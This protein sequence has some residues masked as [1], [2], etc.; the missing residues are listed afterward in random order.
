VSAAV[1]SGRDC[2]PG[3]PQR[4]RVGTASWT[5]PTLIS[6]GTFYPPDAK[7]AEERLRFYAEHFDTVEVD[8]TYYALPSEKNAE[9]W[10]ERTPEGFVFHVKA[11]A[12]L[13]THAAETARLPRAIREMLSEEESGKPRLSRP[14]DEVLAL[15]FQMFASALEP[16]RRAGKLGFLLFQFPPWFSA[17]RGNA[18]TI[19]ACRERLPADALAVEF[20]HSSWLDESRRARTF[21]L[22]RDLDCAYVVVDEPQVAGA[23]PPLFETT[24]A[25]AYVRLHGRN[26]ETWAKKGISPA[27]RFK[28]LYSERELAEVAAR[29]KKLGARTAHV[30]FN[31]C[32]ANFGVMNATTMK[33]ILNRSEQ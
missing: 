22:L 14:R 11:F 24:S 10:S 5:D 13:T 28:Y 4:F 33:Q 25:D 2:M 6:S 1:A 17:T 27:E 16:L 9:R 7:T 21:D 29:V 15:A 26:A 31:N 32:Y 20:R 12:W 18:R 23:V 19:A 3:N 30:I 8:S